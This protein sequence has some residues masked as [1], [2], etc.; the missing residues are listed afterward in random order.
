MR[1]DDAGAA[2]VLRPFAAPAHPHEHCVAA[3]LAEAESACRRSGQRLTTLR[4]RVLELVWGGHGPVKAYD[5]LGRLRAERA[6]AAPPTVYRALDFLCQEGLVHRIESLNAYVG[7]GAPQR[8]HRAQFLICREC[9]TVA[10]LADSEVSGLIAGRA[11][12]MGFEVQRETIEVAGRCATCREGA[13]ALSVA[14][15]SPP[16]RT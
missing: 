7:C 14:P 9:G 8:P 12:R 6:R 11:D 3:A 4:R 1:T 10:E 13:R 15:D 5:L 2:R 16:P